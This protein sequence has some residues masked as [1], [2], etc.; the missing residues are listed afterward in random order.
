LGLFF[1]PLDQVSQTPFGD[2]QSSPAVRKQLDRI[3]E[4]FLNNDLEQKGVQSR[5]RPAQSGRM[6]HWVHAGWS[7]GKACLQHHPAR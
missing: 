1:S 3:S 5:T 7:A 4:A 6:P 2:F